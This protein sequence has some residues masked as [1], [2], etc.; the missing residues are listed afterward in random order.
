VSKLPKNDDD[1]DDVHSHHHTDTHSRGANPH[2]TI[3]SSTVF[4][5]GAVQHIAVHYACIACALFA[6]IS[7]ERATTAAR[8]MQ[9][10]GNLP[11]QRGILSFD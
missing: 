6:Y 8:G 7:A 5:T 3:S 11:K 1:D 10:F 4:S 2:P 9:H